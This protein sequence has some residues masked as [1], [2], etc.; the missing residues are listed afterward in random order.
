MKPIEIVGI[1]KKEPPGSSLISPCRR[2]DSEL[3]IVAV[4]NKKV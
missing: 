3:V 1:I 2:Y 4:I